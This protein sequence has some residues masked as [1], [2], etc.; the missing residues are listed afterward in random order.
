MVYF[1]PNSGLNLEHREL[2]LKNRSSLIRQLKYSLKNE[3]SIDMVLFLNGIPLLTMELKNQLT[4]QDF[5]NSEA[6]YRRD[7]D[8][9]EPLLRFKQLLAHFCVDNDVVTMTTQLMGD[10]T[11]FLP[12]NKGIANPPNPN[13]YRTHYLWEEILAPD[14][15]LDIIENYVHLSREVDKSWDPYKGKVVEKP[16]ELLIFPRY[17]Q[18]DCVRKIRDQVRVEGTGHHYLIQHTTGSGKSYEI[19]WLSHLLTSLYRSKDE[20]HRIFDTII[21]VTDRKVLD[22]QL[23]NT[24]TQ[25]EQTKGVVNSVDKDSHQLQEFLEQSKDIII[26]TIQK[27]PKISETIS[28]LKS[29]TFGV[30]IDEVHSSQTG[31]TSKHL[32]KTISKGES[33]VEEDEELPDYEDL[34]REEIRN[35]GRQE[36]VSFF[37]FTGT[38]KNQTRCCSPSSTAWWKNGTRSAT[39]SR[40]TS[41]SR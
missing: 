9:K 34:I 29:K 23:Q 7:R 20:T 17:H 15:L 24:I 4:G 40:R 12:Y 28:Q 41:L 37:G 18:L 13:G 2:Y 11:K 22:K 39:P 10:D 19:G 38:P 36:H 1:E 14:S 33:G 6:Q 35:R 8:P 3:N 27:F 25:L 16:K 32:K 21:V 31:E 26:S 5:R 30:I